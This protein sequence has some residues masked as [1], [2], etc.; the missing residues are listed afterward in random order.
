[1]K[2][3]LDPGLHRDDIFAGNYRERN[4]FL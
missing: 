3:K 1:M 4:Y 2:E